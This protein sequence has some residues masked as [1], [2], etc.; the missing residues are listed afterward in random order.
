M[1]YD[2]HF[3]EFL[4]PSLVDFVGGDRDEMLLCPIRAIKK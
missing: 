1:W 2:L 3:E 4:V